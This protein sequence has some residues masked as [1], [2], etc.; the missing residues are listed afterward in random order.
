MSWNVP[1]QRYAWLEQEEGMWHFLTDL[2][3]DPGNSTRKWPDKV[4]ALE[5]LREE[6]WTVVSP[7]PD[8]PQKAC[9]YGLMWISN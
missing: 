3:A 8:N 1:M 5:E 2:F 7:Y 6:G 9:G 4:Q